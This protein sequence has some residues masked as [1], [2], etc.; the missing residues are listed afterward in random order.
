MEQIEKLIEQGK[1]WEAIHNIGQFMRE[2]KESLSQD[3]WMEF[4]HKDIHNSKIQE[5]CHLCPFTRRNYEKPRGYSGDAITLDYIYGIPGILDHSKLDI[6]AEEVFR[7]AVGTSATRAVRYRRKRAS[8]YLDDACKQ[9]EKSTNIFS[10]ACGHLREVELSREIQKGNFAS[11]IAL[12]QDQKSLKLVEECY[13][14]YGVSTLNDS[15]KNLITGQRT[16]KN[17][18][19]QL[20]YSLGLY[21]YLQQEY[22]NLLTSRLFKYLAPGGRMVLANF[23]PNI[24]YIGYMEALMDW[25]LIY[26]SET[27]MQTLVT[28]IKQHIQ[29]SHLFRDPDENI[30]FMEIIKKV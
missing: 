26:R 28:G 12:D 4:I 16:F 10:V 15:I 7:Y 27:E 5:F 9:Y 29:G 8:Q 23:L 1:A 2:K 11:F 17:N 14:R 3:Q 20:I 19:F 21:D 25:W 18:S 22:A 30:V 24:P 13:G 6:I